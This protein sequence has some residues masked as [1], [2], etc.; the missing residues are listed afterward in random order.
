MSLEV[1]TDGQ[2]EVVAGDF[3]GLVDQRRQV[4]RGHFPVAAAAETEH[5]GDDLCRPCPGLLD[6]VEQLRDFAAC[7]VLVDGVQVDSGLFGVL[8]VLRQIRGQA[9]ANV[10]HVMQDR[11]QRIVDLVGHAGGES[12]DRKHLFRLHHHFFQGQ[13]LGDVVDADH[14][15]AAGTAHQRVEGQGIVAGLVV[16]DPGDALDLRHAVLFDGVLELRQ[17]GFQRFEGEEDRLV[18]RLVQAGSGEC[19]GLLV[20][21]GDVELLVQGDQRRGH[22]VDDAVEVVL[23]TGEFFLDLAADLDLEF[24]L[25]VGMPGFLGKALGLVIGGLGVVTGALELLLAG[26]D[27]REHGV[28]GL[29][30]AA[31]FIVIAP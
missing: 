17:K 29:G 21:L 1:E 18:Q 6:A 19:A 25:A 7:Q 9:P 23:E 3:H 13:A 27:A 2:V 11:P 15:A 10:L 26:F 5:V 8:E 28:E 14:H 12:A 24:Q 31:D 30:Q 16:L 4:A 22:G 20:P